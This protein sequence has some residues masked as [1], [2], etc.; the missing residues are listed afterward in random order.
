M[1]CPPVCQFPAPPPCS[2]NLW[3]CL[4][5]SVPAPA[6]TLSPASHLV[7]SSLSP[8]TPELALLLSCSQ[9]GV[10]DPVSPA[11]SDRILCFR[12]SASSCSPALL[13]CPPLPLHML[14]PWLKCP[15]TLTGLA[16]PAHP[17]PSAQRLR[18]AFPDFSGWA[19]AVWAPS[20]QHR[21][22]PWAAWEELLGSWHPRDALEGEVYLTEVTVG[23]A[24]A[25]GRSCSSVG[26]DV[27][28]EP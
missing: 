15:F 4:R 14:F 22:G 28:P 20:A 5:P 7:S 2:L 9:P 26:G 19:G 1:P 23:T 13:P 17:L 21:A 11:S 16:N 10:R 8:R 25:R 12:F 6:Q 3:A 18:K 24:G 27:H